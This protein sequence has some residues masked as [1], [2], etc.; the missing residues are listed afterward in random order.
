[1]AVSVP[2][3]SHDKKTL[4]RAVRLR[5]A[6][7]NIRALMEEWH[8]AVQVSSVQRGPF[9]IRYRY[10]LAGFHANVRQATR[11]APCV[12]ALPSQGVEIAA[13]KPLLHI[14]WD[15]DAIVLALFERGPWE[16]EFLRLASRKPG[17]SIS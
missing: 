13:K 1:M 12:D 5:D 4:A 15:G 3:N 16:A 6:A 2:T 10:P 17:K 14:V 9:R 8:P 11:H 7:L